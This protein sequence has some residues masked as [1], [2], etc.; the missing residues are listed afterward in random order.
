GV[1]FTR[2]PA[3]GA[4]GLYIDYL[5]NAQG[6]DVVAGRRN[7]LGAAELQHRVPKAYDELTGYCTVLER[8]F[9]DMQDFEF[10]VED[11]R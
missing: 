8:A 10:T 7:A 6:E 11:G 9:A 3:D 5:P 4:N 2:S 1:G